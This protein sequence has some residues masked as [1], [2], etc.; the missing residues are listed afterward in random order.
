MQPSNTTGRTLRFA[1]MPIS[2]IIAFLVV[3]AV[4]ALVA[5]LSSTTIRGLFQTDSFWPLAL[6]LPAFFFGK[7][8]GLMTLNVVAFSIPAARRVF[9]AEVSETGR[10]SFRKAM[11]GLTRIATVLGLVTAFTVIAY[12]WIN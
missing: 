12:L 3:Y 10:H 7:I 11:E 5:S 4:F 8:L 2:W 1:M 9:D 6:F